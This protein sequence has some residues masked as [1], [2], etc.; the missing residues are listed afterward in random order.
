[1]SRPRANVILGRI[2]KWSKFISDYDAYS[3]YGYLSGY[4]FGFFLNGYTY[5][6]PLD[7]PSIIKQGVIQ[8]LGDNLGILIRNILLGHVEEIK[9]LLDADPLIYFDI[10]GRYLIVYKTSTSITIQKI[11]I[12][13]IIIVGI[14]LIISDHIWHRQ[15]LLT[16]NDSRCI[17]FYFKSP[18]T[19]R[20]N[21]IILYLIS[22][23][24]SVVVGL[25]VQ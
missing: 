24:I 25:F 23:L 14:I 3:V 20:I 18:S 7:H 9:N 16:C 19:V 11:L 8:D 22:N 10:L 6:T 4:D 15:R 2:P 13:L 5:H 12:V 17:Y 21:S 1:M